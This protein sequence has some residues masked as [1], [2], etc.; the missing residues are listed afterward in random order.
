GADGPVC[1]RPGPNQPVG[2]LPL[3]AAPTAPP[4]RGTFDQ[5][6]PVIDPAQRTA[7]VMGT[8]PNPEIAPGERKLRAGQLILAEISLPAA[9]E[10]GIVP[11]NA[12]IELRSDYSVFL[13]ADPAVPH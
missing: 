8:I 12:L 11:N 10:E 1:Q 7:A 5:I 6:S 9:A 13:Q 4:L 3:P 2:N